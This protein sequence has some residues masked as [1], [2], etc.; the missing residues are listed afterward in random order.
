MTLLV[1][2]EGR[3]H[4]HPRLPVVKTVDAERMRE[5]QDV[6]RARNEWREETVAKKACHRVLQVLIVDGVLLTRMS[7]GK[8]LT[9]PSRHWRVRCGSLLEWW[10]Q[11]AQGP[12]Q[13]PNWALV[14]QPW[15]QMEY[16]GMH[17]TAVVVT[18]VAGFVRADDAP[19]G[20]DSVEEDVRAWTG[21]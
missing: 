21:V 6:D 3:A 16:F 8:G 9:R 7:R 15:N 12:S 13:H 18:K 4:A 20:V 17:R 19:S 2:E 5:Y 1:V 11:M 14:L 10:S